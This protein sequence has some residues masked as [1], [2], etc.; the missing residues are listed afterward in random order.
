[1]YK[2][3]ILLLII[4]CSVTTQ[5]N[6]IEILSPDNYAEFAFNEEIVVNFAGN[7]IDEWEVESSSPPT[8]YDVLGNH[9]FAISFT[10]MRSVEI[11]IHVTYKD[12]TSEDAS[13]IVWLH[14]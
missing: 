10:N 1:M 9:S 3:L 11:T 13:L 12:N 14:P 7:N 6:F 4:G 5:P 8:Y 2:Y